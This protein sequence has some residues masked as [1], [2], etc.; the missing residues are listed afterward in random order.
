MD[1]AELPLAPSR[2]TPMRRL[3]T[4]VEVA[5]AVLFLA[6]QEASYI[7]GVTLHVAGGR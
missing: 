6:S 2:L 7:T 4:P 5:H 1:E 3:G